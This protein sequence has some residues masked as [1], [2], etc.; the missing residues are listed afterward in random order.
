M[1]EK[2]K[3]AMMTNNYKP[4][5]AGVPISVDRLTESLREMGHEVVV[6]APDYEGCEEEADVVRCRSLI[7]GIYCGFSLPDRFDPKIERRFKEEAFDVIHVHHPMV[8]GKTAAYL[9][10]KYQVPLVFTYHTRYEQYLHYLGLAAFGNLI[11]HYVRHYTKNCSMVIA[12]TVTMREQL[13]KMEIE[14]PVTVLPT[15][16]PEECFSPEEEQVEKYRKK[17]LG[18]KKYLFCT[19]ARLAKE[20]KIE[21]LLKALGERKRKGK[22]D[23]RLALIGEGPNEKALRELTEELDLTENIEFV[24]KVQNNEIKNYCKASDLFLFASTS[25]TQ[26]IVLLEAMAAGTPVLAVEATGTADL[27][28]NGLN[29]AMTGEDLEQYESRLEELLK[30]DSYLTLREGAVKTARFYVQGEVAKRAVTCYLQT[31]ENQKLRQRYELGRKYDILF[32]K[33]RGI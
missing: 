1:E 31:A 17:L 13:E 6:F 14:T 27:V 33:V 4:F 23:F 19:I 21:F 20:K 32:K 16:I 9:S 8:M 3:I 22:N 30:E 29:G 18:D 11:P 12:P 7:Q 10:K 25:E 2:M 26:G 24:G 5:I 28:K 15:G